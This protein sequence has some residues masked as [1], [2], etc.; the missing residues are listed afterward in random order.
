MHLLA[1]VVT[2]TVSECEPRASGLLAMQR[3]GT[4]TPSLSGYSA[5]V[6]ELEVSGSS[7]KLPVGFRGLGFRGLEV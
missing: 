2:L 7:K 3:P 1:T 5:Q 4:V 6:S